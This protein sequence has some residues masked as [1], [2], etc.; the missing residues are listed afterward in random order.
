MDVAGISTAIGALGFPIVAC[1][2]IGWYFVKQQEQNNATIS[3]LSE[4]LN[5]NT[6]ALTKLAEKIDKEV[7]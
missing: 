6:I 5:N 1:V 2:A 7:Q 4:A 3:K